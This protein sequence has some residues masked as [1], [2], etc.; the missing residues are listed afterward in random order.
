MAEGKK[1]FVLYCDIVHTVDQ[2]TDEQAGKLF[3]HILHYVNDRDPQTDDILTRLTF[4]PI[5]QQLK[6]D[7]SK[8]ERRAE[9][10]RIN[11]SSGGRPKNQEEPKKPNGLF[12]N[13]TEPK[14][15]DTDTVTD[16]VKVKEKRE[17][18]I[19]PTH[20]LIVWI[21]TNAPT[22]QKLKSPL[23]NSEATDL[24]TD[25]AIDTDIKKVR[26]KD[27]L[28]GMENKPDLLKKYKSANLTIRKWWK[29]ETE[30]NPITESPTIKGKRLKI[31]Y[32]PSN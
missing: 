27:I 3:K 2:M 7:L 20:P 26:L 4:E 16:T 28:T 24:I 14:K 18:A 32:G 6:R 5:K 17:D 11:G 23:T 12:P 15:P 9:Q 19:A 21:N 30:R 31:D 29:L 25:L 8:Y 13:P 1:A 10:S 22:V